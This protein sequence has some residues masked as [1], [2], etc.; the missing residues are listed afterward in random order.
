M[1]KNKT[2]V[3]RIINQRKKNETR[4][5]GASA[6]TAARSGIKLQTAGNMRLIKTRGPRIRRK[7]KTRR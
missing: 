1:G 5:F 2:N 6:I 4:N 7:K 3:L